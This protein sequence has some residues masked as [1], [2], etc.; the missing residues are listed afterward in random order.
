ML[1]TGKHDVG[2]LHYRSKRGRLPNF[3]A[4]THTHSHA[5]PSGSQS[6][7]SMRSRA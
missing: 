2:T 3:Q 5:G 1:L 6:V 4:H 7:G